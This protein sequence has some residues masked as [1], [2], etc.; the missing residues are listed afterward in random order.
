MTVFPPNGGKGSTSLLFFPGAPPS[1]QVYTSENS[2]LS[3]KCT[4]HTPIAPILRETLYE[5]IFLHMI[6]W[7]GYV[8]KKV[9]GWCFGVLLPLLICSTKRC[10]LLFV[11]FQ[12]LCSGKQLIECLHSLWLSQ[13][14]LLLWKKY[15]AKMF[16]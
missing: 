10:K 8:V 6:G 11:A 3:V 12:C 4:L 2:I 13:F 5:I 15:L 1:F 9:N 7:V 14:A 16:S